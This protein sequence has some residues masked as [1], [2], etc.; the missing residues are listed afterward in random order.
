MAKKYYKNKLKVKKKFLLFLLF[1]IFI[2]FTLFYYRMIIL[3]LFPIKIQSFI[4]AIQSNELTTNKLNN[5]YNV[6]FIPETQ[7]V[8]LKFEKYSLN[9]FKNNNNN[10]NYKSFSPSYY[11][12]F[13]FSND[14]NNIFFLTKN[15]E[16]YYENLDNIIGVNK[17]NRVKKVGSNI[18]YFEPLDMLIHNKTI[19]ISGAKI[20]NENCAKF[21]ILESK[22]SYDYL[23]FTEIFNINKCYKKI[24]SGKLQA[25]NEVEIIVSTAADVLDFDQV[26]PKPQDNNSL[27]GKTLIININ[28]KDYK[29]FSKGH[30]NILGLYVDKSTGIVLGTDN[31][32]YG[33]DEINLLKNGSNYGWPISS[34]GEKYNFKYGDKPKYKKNKEKE[35]FEEPIFSLIPSVGISQII[36]IENFSEFWDNNF[37][38]ASLNSGHLFRFLFDD[39]FTKAIYYEK[40]YVGERIR[41]ILYLEKL[42]IILLA[43]ENS[44]SLGVIK[45]Y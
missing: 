3:D 37:L 34:Y 1:S 31:G 27:M 23:N 29:I 13:F 5:D 14:E 17:V 42:K 30:R 28:N 25:Y 15:S 21:T 36:K 6:K 41:T 11:K 35:N 4:R 9:I 10:N 33:G 38:I 20:I 18:N 43:L 32:P 7:F 19:Y 8:K 16:I 22:I 40:I 24:Q 2:I 26:D 44:G 39:K 12:T 45:K